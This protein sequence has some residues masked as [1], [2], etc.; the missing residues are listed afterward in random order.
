MNPIYDKIGTTYNQTRKADARIISRIVELL[1]LPV[2][3]RILDVGAGTGSYS[4]ALASLGYNMTALEPSR[5]MRE[6][7][8][9]DSQITWISGIAEALPF[10]DGEFDAAIL[11]LCIHHFNDPA[12]ALREVRRVCGSGPIL[13][14]TYDPEAIEKPWLFEYFPIFRTQIQSSFPFVADIKKHL[15]GD[16]EFLALPFPLPHDLAD[17]FAGSAWRYPER[18]LESEFRNGTSAFR[19]LDAELCQIGLD[20]LSADLKSGAWE[21]RYGE[22]RNL[23]QYD[24]GYTFLLS[25]GKRF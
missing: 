23:D 19:Q 12:A 21:A 14:F 5:I 3:S 17:G 4:M 20:S 11:I 15:A 25:I 22:L 8:S 13:I 2:G 10:S 1:N 6:Q 16:E 18:Y 7:A 9:D 24:H